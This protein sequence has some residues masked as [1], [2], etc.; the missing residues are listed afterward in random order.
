[1]SIFIRVAL[2][3]ILFETSCLA[4]KGAVTFYSPGISLKSEAAG[5]LPKSQQPFDGRL[6]DG[7]QE[8][9][10]FRHGRFAVF[11]LDPGAHS[12]NLRGPEGSDAGPLVINVEN[13]G[14]YC[15]RLSARMT[16]L[17]G[18]YLEKNQIEV[19]P[20]QQAQREAAHL[21]AIETK[22]VSPAVRG[23]L[24]QATS[25]PHDSSTQH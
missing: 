25:F 3:A 24:D 11:H 9:A 15:V 21:K 4:Q 2:F 19:V 7:T 10:Q 14:H 1:M 23:D 22:R 8:L 6:F 13:G 18:F 5:M 12:F 17:A 16:N 20:C